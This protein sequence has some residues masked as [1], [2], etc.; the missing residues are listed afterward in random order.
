MSFEND[1]KLHAGD[2]MIE[3]TIFFSIYGAQYITGM[4][5]KSLVKLILC[6]ESWGLCFLII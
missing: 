5:C 6:L 2:T 4:Y 1:L 3:L